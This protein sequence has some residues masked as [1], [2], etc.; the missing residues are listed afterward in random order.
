MIDVLIVDDTLV[1]QGLLRGILSEDP[2]FRVVGIAQNGRQ[3]VEMVQS[4]KPHVV[5][6]DIYMPVMDGVEATKKIMQTT[7]VP[8]VIVS[9]FYNSSEVQMSFNILKAGALT[10][11]PRPFG[12][13]HPQYLQTARTYRNTLKMMAVVK[14]GLHK[15]PK[16]LPSGRSAPVNSAEAGIKPSPP[17]SKPQ[18]VVITN[19][20][21][22]KPGRVIAIGASAGGPQ[23]IQAILSGLDVSL[24]VPVMIVQHIDSHFAE[25]FRDWLQSNSK[26]PVHTAVH[27]QVMQPG[28]AYL[29]PGDR[30]LGVLQP[31][32]AAVSDEPAEKGLRPAVS[33]L[34][35]KVQEVYLSE[36]VAILLSGMGTD[37]AS[38]LKLLYD[39]GA[40][41]IAQDSESS[42]VHGM[43][44]EAIRQGGVSLIS[45]PE[46]ISMHLN[47]LYTIIK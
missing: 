12:P 21:A 15:A 18:T 29:A 45:N 38:E 41:T 30:H 26:L 11:L 2:A 17:P 22:M 13:G 36:A 40:F 28:H 47:E 35:R 39:A 43:P 1:G 34:F 10:I 7:P 16:P 5:S 31:G 20:I 19:K 3:A 46:S 24:P 6:M 14:V 8:I 44:G 23:A 27:G 37:G 9:S 33:Y 4:L 42:L 25:G 32:V